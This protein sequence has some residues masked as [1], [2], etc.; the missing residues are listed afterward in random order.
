MIHVV[1]HRAKKHFSIELWCISVIVNKSTVTSSTQ[2]LETRSRAKPERII[3]T[4]FDDEHIEEIYNL[5]KEDCDIDDECT[6]SG[7]N[8]SS[9]D[10]ERPST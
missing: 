7:L 5:R 3:D 4:V 6:S 10:G 2:V 1:K 8:V 9:S